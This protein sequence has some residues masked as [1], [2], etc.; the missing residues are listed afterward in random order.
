M[1]CYVFV[2]ARVLPRWNNHRVHFG[3]HEDTNNSRTHQHRLIYLTLMNCK[4]NGDCEQLQEPRFLFQLCSIFFVRFYTENQEIVLKYFT[5]CLSAFFV[6][7]SHQNDS[8]KN[9]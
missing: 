8:H 9:S 6:R 5:A 7:G 2:H 3:A 4:L 1:E